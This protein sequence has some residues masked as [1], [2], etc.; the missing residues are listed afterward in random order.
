MH[1]DVRSSLV[2]FFFL[3]AISNGCCNVFYCS[4]K[5]SYSMTLKVLI[6]SE[7]WLAKV[8]NDIVIKKYQM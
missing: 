6:F 1:N 5:Q 8:C 3:S 7:P 4:F 2:V